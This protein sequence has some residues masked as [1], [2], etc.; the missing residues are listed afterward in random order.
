MAKEV[1]VYSSNTCPHCVT[2]KEYLS[3]KG[4]AFTE[5]NVSVDATARK[6]LMKKGIMA[7]PVVEIDGETVVGFDRD[8]IEDLLR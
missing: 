6:E 2:V 7:V 5:K 1:I 8:R 4:V 3:D